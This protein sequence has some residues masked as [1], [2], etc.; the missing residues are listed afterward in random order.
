M[1]IHSSQ[2]TKEI[3]RYVTFHQQYRKNF[4]CIEAFVN[5]PWVSSTDF[6]DY[7]IAPDM[8]QLIPSHIY[9]TVYLFEIST[10]QRHILCPVLV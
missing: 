3:R 7:G 2:P 4:I 9:W 8:S 6:W 10:K 5:I 1:Q